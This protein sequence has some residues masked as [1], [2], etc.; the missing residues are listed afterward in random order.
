MLTAISGS[1]WPGA[2]VVSIVVFALMGWVGA[3]RLW[4]LR[5]FTDRTMTPAEALRWTRRYF[6]RFFRLFVLTVLAAAPLGIPVAIGVVR[7]TQTAARSGEDIRL[8]VGL[9]VYMSAVALVIDFALTFVTPALVYATS[10]AREAVG[11]GF[12]L[13][14]ATWPHAAPYVLL[15][16]LA[17]VVLMRM[18]SDSVGMLGSTVVV[19]TSLLSLIAR[20][21]TCALYLRVMTP[22]GPDG[23]TAA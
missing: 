2:S 23:A 10:S 1:R 16:P 21:A 8:G 5:A 15:P 18:F 9:L 6:G 13:L 22:A 20:G 7:A 17:V 4:Y 14:R 3:E 12:R 19:L 11:I